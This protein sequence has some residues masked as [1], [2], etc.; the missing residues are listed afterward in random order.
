VL[1]LVDLSCHQIHKE[2]M[3]HKVPIGI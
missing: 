1:N 3:T 2:A